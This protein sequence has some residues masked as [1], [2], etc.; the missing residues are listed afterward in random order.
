ML[1]KI[2]GFFAGVVS[3]VAAIFGIKFYKEKATRE[4]EHLRVVQNNRDVFNSIRKKVQPRDYAERKKDNDEIDVGYD[5][6]N[7]DDVFNDP[8]LRDSDKKD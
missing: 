3:L 8:V 5:S 6:G 1:S 4:K 7:L 2:L